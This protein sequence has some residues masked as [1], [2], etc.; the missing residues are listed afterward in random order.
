MNE[1]LLKHISD[2]ESSVRT[3]KCLRAEGIEYIKDLVV[4]TEAQMMLIPNFGKRSLN[5]LKDILKERGLGFGT[6]IH[7]N[8]NLD[9]L[10]RLFVDGYEKRVSEFLHTIFNN[11]YFANALFLAEFNSSVILHNANVFQVIKP[12]ID[13]WHQGNSKE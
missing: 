4:K 10:T 7:I 1:E 3:Y 5:E 2:L 6:D 12:G 9:R 8:D 13:M 11:Y